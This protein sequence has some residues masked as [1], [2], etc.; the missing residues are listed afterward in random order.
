MKP[1][2]LPEGLNPPAPWGHQAGEDQCSNVQV[3]N[4]VFLQFSSLVACNRWS[5]WSCKLVS[6][7]MVSCSW[8]LVACSLEFECLQL[9]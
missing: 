7:S 1:N 2:R 6:V 5:M 4:L 9:G 3:G 8:Q